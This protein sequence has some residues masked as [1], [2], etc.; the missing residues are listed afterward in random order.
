[1]SP[2]PD[3]I[4]DD[5]REC[6]RMIDS[7][8]VLGATRQLALLGECLLVLARSGADDST[9]RTAAA[10]LVSHIA[11]S[12]GESSQAVINGLRLMAAPALATSET[13]RALAADIEAAVAAFLRSL[14][15]WLTDVRRNAAQLLSTY[16]TFL[17]YDYSSTVSHALT[18]L[19]SS[20][21]AVTVFLPEARSL[22]GGSKYLA[23]WQNLGITAHLIPDA[24][25]GWALGQCDVALV[26]AETLSG[27]GGCYNTIGSA[28]TAHEAHRRHVPFYV[29][30]VLLKTD[31]H[32]L[33]GERPIPAL[34]FASGSFLP[35]VPTMHGVEIRGG[36]PDLDYT[37]PSAITGVVTEHGTLDPRRVAAAA[38]PLVGHGVPAHG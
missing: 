29:L 20:G 12:R 28:L 1:M 24:A 36:F 13:G 37:P 32:T 4:T 22:G 11:L 5:A 14:Q 9:L 17:A 27:E 33:G 7:G 26:G 38:S 35:T 3:L 19:R 31:P 10:S 30:S 21:R 23:D 15:T 25:L 6:L 8:E 2:A 34:D 18:D 16:G